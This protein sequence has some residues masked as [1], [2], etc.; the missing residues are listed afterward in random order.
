MKTLKIGFL[1]TRPKQSKN[2]ARV[3][4]LALYLSRYEFPAHRLIALQTISPVRGTNGF[5]VVV[6]DRVVVVVVVV[7][8]VVV[9]LVINRNF[10]VIKLHYGNVYMGRQESI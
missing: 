10:E 2:S 9:V 6:G 4:I 1:A 3:I 5:C 8:V 7:G